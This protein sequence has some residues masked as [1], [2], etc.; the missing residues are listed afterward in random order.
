MK[1]RKTGLG[2]AGGAKL[3]A[4][5]CATLTVLVSA[6]VSACT[7]APSTTHP[8]IFTPSSPTASA[9][10]GSG[11]TKTP[12]TPTASHTHSASASASGHPSA[13][14]TS[15]TKQP[16]TTP[17]SPAAP[18]THPPT[19]YPPTAPATSYPA[20]A[21]STGGGGTAGLQ[22][23]LLFGIGGG[24]MLAGFGSL[25]YRRRVNRRK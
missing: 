16:T 13:A 3:T 2:T 25:A 14:T 19:T 15:P 5:S 7:G 18:T 12:E 23:T 21:P 17:A 6:T 9:H 10:P 20:A 11:A 1:V 8:A 24:A 4:V 22:D